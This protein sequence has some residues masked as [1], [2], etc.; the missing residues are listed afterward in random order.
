MLALRGVNISPNDPRVLDDRGVETKG[1]VGSVAY[2][3]PIEGNTFS[4]ALSDTKSAKGTSHICRK[5]N[6]AISVKL[7]YA[8]GHLY[9]SVAGGFEKYLNHR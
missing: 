9:G 1:E 4:P 7:G 3:D 5:K 8:V 2:S 6:E